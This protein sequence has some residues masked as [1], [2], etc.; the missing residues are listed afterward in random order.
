MIVGKIE[1]NEGWQLKFGPFVC[2]TGVHEGTELI[3]E[4]VGAKL[5]GIIGVEIGIERVKMISQHSLG[6]LD[7]LEQRHCPGPRTGAGVRIAN[8]RRQPLT[9]MNFCAWTSSLLR[10]RTSLFRCRSLARFVAPLGTHKLPVIA[11]G[12][13]V[14]SKVVP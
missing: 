8:I 2:D 3:Q 10:R 1:Q 14:V 13:A 12:Q 6:G 9:Y 4:F 7:L 11:I 5:V